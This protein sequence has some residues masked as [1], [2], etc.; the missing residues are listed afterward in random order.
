MPTRNGGPCCW[1]PVGGVIAPLTVVGLV[2]CNQRLRPIRPPMASVSKI[3]TA[4]AA[5]IAR[6]PQEIRLRLVRGIANGR[7][8]WADDRDCCLGDVLRPPGIATSF[9]RPGVSRLARP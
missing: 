6:N 5:C 3:V 4:I 9:G 7:L 2:G 8:L 1:R